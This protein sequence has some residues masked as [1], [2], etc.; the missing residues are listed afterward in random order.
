MLVPIVISMFGF[1]VSGI[2][3]F[4]FSDIGVIPETIQSWMVIVSSALIVFGAEANTPGTVIEVFRK[5]LRKEHNN[6]DISALV[7]SLVGTVI[8][9]LVTFASRT[10]LTPAWRDLLLNWGPLV[11]GFAVACDYYG[12]LLETGFLFGSFELRTEKWLGE[13]RAFDE[14]NGNV[15]LRD[16]RRPELEFDL[17]WP[18]ATIDEVR[19]L[20]SSLNGARATLTE[21]GLLRLLWK[22]ERRPKSPSTTKRWASRARRGIL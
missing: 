4:A 13:K 21:D 18:E 16:V 19:E 20:T 22:N 7:L 3:A 14:A 17:S 9:L 2:F 10:K 8:N 11:S 12:G 5:L 15:V 1:F 6:W